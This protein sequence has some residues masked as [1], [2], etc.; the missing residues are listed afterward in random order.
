MTDEVPSTT[1]N[2]ARSDTDTDSEENMSNPTK[3][4]LLACGSFNPVTNMH[5]RMFEIA[6]DALHRTQ[7]FTVIKGIISPVS[8][9]YNKKDLLPS[10]HRCEMLKQA[11][12]SNN[13]I[14]LDTWECEQSKWL[15]TA[16]V[17]KY[18]QAK[19]DREYTTKTK[20]APTKKRRK[21]LRNV[22]INSNDSEYEEMTVDDHNAI[23]A[24]LKKDSVNVRL[25]CGA[26]LL[27]SFGTPGLWA[28]KDIEDIVGK[29]GLVCI[30]RA[31]SDPRRFIYESDVLTKYQENI[32]IVTEWIFNDISSTKIRRA[33]RRG[34]SVK[35]LL[36]DVVIDYIKEN[37]L[38]GVEDNKYVN[39]IIP[40][41]MADSAFSEVQW[42]QEDQTS[43]Q[44]EVPRSPKRLNE[45]PFEGPPSPKSPRHVP[46]MGPDLGSLVRRVRNYSFRQGMFQ[47]RRVE[48]Q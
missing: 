9:G 35:Y 36:Q 42:N 24:A 11:L 12:K 5:L 34:E 46:C 3:C 44:E 22:H 7:K 21:D 32:F 48:N 39:D 23:N 13:W 14:N 26:D 43:D 2:T 45:E 8:D 17:L 6:R 4:V 27:E 16:K 33:L 31:G 47:H 30:T 25:L 40:S 37:H 29:Y 1:D 28:D 15:E 20:P 18:H 38:Y 19:V 10:S 41:P